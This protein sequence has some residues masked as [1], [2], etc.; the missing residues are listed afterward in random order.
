M[1]DDQARINFNTSRELKRR[2]KAVASLCGY[3]SIPEGFT[4]IFELGI[5]AMEAGNKKSKKEDKK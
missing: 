3:D 4:R 1:S 2:A 5:E